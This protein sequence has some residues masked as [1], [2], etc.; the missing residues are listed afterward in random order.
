V[1]VYGTV[2]DYHSFHAMMLFEEMFEKY[3]AA[4]QNGEEEQ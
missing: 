1:K 3:K 4:K 2:H